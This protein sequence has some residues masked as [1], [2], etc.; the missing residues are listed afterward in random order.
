MK[1]A[2]TIAGSDSGGGAGIQA[3]LKAFHANGVFGMSAI[4][5]VTA[6]NTREVRDAFDL[7][8][9]LVVAQIDAVF[10]DFDVSAVKTGM[11]SS[12]PIVRAVSERLQ[13][14]QVDNLVVDPVMVSKSGFALLKPDAVQ[15][16]RDRLLPLASVVTPNL[17]EAD[18]L[19]GME[20]D[21][22]EQAK[23]AGRRILD[24]GPGAV[25]VKGGHL[26]DSVRAV[27]VLLAGDTAELFESERFDTPNTHGTGCTY[28]AAIA[29]HL[30]RGK[31]L[32]DAVRHA[33]AYI[34]EAIRHSL[35]I[36]QGH[37]PTNH[38][39]F[40]PGTQ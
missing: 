24:A 16:V 15:A 33:K 1:Q 3:D 38:F 28:S 9:D 12:E 10:D 35:D 4:T 2:L 27:D 26:S 31:D 23:E 14:H 25:L 18:L 30:A 34:T 11:L 13:H 39:Y 37:G 22:V 36:G 21:T 32:K 19:S 20:V 7:P 8:V 29:A 40:L 17:H 6:Q 5:S